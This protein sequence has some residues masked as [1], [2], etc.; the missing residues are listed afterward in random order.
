MAAVPPHIT[1]MSWV[2]ARDVLPH[3]AHDFTP[4]LASNLDLLAE[5]L[6]LDQLELVATEWQVETFALDI[7]ARGSDADGDVMVVIENQY[8]MTDHR[9][10]GQILTY[11]AHAAAAG[12]RVLAVWLTEETRPAHLAAVEFLNRV[13]S[14]SDGFG[15]LLLRVRFAPAPDGWHVHFEVDAEP[16][17]FLRQG[18]PKS[19]GGGDESGS[20]HARGQFIV[21]VSA[22]LDPMLEPVGVRRR[23]RIITKHGAVVYKFPGTLEV[24]RLATARVVSSANTSN[25]A[26]YLERYPATREN[27][28][29][30]EL[31]R[32]TYEDLA[33][34]YGVRVDDWHGSGPSVKR[35]RVITEL[36]LGYANAEPA[37]L[38]KQASDIIKGWSRMLTE[39]PLNG[40]EQKVAA[41][42]AEVGGAEA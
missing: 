31:L 17:A 6:G 21:K 14:E 18:T 15:M 10:L 27:W 39:H 1:P 30:A 19:G 9:H 36:P 22:H 5:V 33:A 16:N 41:L 24:S 12:T 42:A 34:G 35:D 23:G 28:A 25:V 2:S 3:E 8:G 38:A 11:A 26:L 4:W 20:D 13:A 7:L 37:T 40:T 29:V 32:Q